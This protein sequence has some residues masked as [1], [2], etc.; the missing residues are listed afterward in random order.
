[1]C[2]GDARPRSVPERCVRVGA[3]AGSHPTPIPISHRA[4]GRGA[5]PAAK[6]LIFI[7]RLCLL[8]PLFFFRA[9]PASRP[10]PHQRLSLSGSPVPGSLVV[11]EAPRPALGRVAEDCHYHVQGCGIHGRRPPTG[12]GA[13][14]SFPEAK[15]SGI[16]F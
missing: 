4:A 1:M 11:G 2:A 15:G 8:K 7:H 3:A 12:L 6:L 9:L 10:S 16:P 5:G 14:V 13:G